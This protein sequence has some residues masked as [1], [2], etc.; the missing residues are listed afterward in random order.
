MNALSDCA[1]LVGIDWADDHHD[2]CLLDRAT[3]QRQQGRINH[4]PEAISDWINQ[5]CERFGGR[6]IAICLEQS[7]GPLIYALMSHAFLLLYPINPRSLARYRETFRPSGPKDDPSDAALLCDLLLKHGE[8]LVPWRPDDVQTRQLTA[9][10]EQRRQFVDVST[11]ATQKL[12]ATLKNYFPQA[13]AWAGEDLNS[14]MACDFLLKW[15]TLQAVQQAKPQALRAF[16]YGHNC[17]S[18][19]LIQ[20]RLEQIRQAQPLTRDPAV[21][22]P[23]VLSVKALA[24]MLR[25]LQSAVA[26]FDRE[27]AALFSQHPDAPL[28]NNLPGAGEQLSPRL[29]CA[30]GT[31]R[32]RYR[33]PTDLQT[34]SGI[35]PVI[36][37]SGKQLW[38]HMRWLRPIFPCQ[39]FYEFAKS[40]VGCSV[41]AAA[42]YRYYAELGKAP[43]AII[44]ALAFKWIRILFRCW[45]DRVP[46]DEI[47]YI[48]TLKKHCAPWMTYLFAAS[49]TA[50]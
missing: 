40:S 49:A 41:W 13:L 47:R 35:A 17:R 30:F 34:F 32:S 45:Q 19:T 16:Y 3:G 11:S 29:L 24:Q 22:E 4:S 9:L 25:S 50:A 10:C 43:H 15:P 46:Y 28:F 31:D 2:Y 6:P 27:I 33:A 7:R 12:I 48:A 38:V 26:A 5:L 20:E 42:Y 36:V 21:I 37:R 14:P 1:A 23:L 8:R 18:E 39:T 44:R